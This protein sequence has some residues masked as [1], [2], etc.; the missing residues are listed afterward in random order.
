[1]VNMSNFQL[2]DRGFDY[3]SRRYQVTTLGASSSHSRAI[4]PLSLDNRDEHR[5]CGNRAV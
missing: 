4:V 2:R 3:Q 1:M 5:P